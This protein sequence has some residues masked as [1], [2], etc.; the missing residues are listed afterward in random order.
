MKPLKTTRQMMAYLCL[1]FELCDNKVTRL[2]KVVY[3]LGSSTVICAMTLGFIS[4]W[5]YFLKLFSVDLA[6]SLYA[7]FQIA[8]C[9]AIL[10]H[11]VF[12][13]V[14]EHNITEAIEKLIEIYKKSKGFY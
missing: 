10:F 7:I 9:S 5:A 12:A 14:L 6:E 11:V 13:H 3:F 8:A 1:N 4:S 2:Q